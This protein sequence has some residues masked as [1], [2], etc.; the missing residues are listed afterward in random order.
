ML[1][2]YSAILAGGSLLYSNNQT[3]K[4]TVMPDKSP[5]VTQMQIPIEWHVPDDVEARYVTNVVVQT[6]EH[7]HL[8]SFFQTLPPIVIGGPAEVE[9]QLKEL[10]SIRAVCVARIIVAS[11]KIPGIIQALQGNL[12]RLAENTEESE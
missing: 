12:N 9:S 3:R 6:V 10:K 5:G 8:I 2:D 4:M 1:Q 7:G 11:E